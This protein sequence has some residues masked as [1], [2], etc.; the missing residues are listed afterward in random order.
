MGSYLLALAALMA[1]TGRLA[2]LYGRRRLFIIGAAL[3]GLGSVACAAAPNLELL[4]YARA[5]EG[6]AGRW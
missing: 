4:I 2:D 5:L 6:W 1:A 3:F